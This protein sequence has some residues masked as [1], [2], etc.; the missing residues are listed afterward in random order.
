[1]V[2]DYVSG[3]QIMEIARSYGCLW[4]GIANRL[5]ERGVYNVQKFCEFKPKDE[6]DVLRR[7]ARGETVSTIARAQDR[8][9][10][11]VKRLLVMRGVYEPGRLQLR[12]KLNERQI[13]RMAQ[14]YEGGTSIYTLAKDYGCSPNGVWK[15][16][17]R[18]GV[19][20]R[21]R[22]RVEGRRAAHD[23]KYMR[24]QVEKSDPIGMAMAW[25]NGYVLEHRLVMAH[26]LGR[27]LESHETVHHI[28]NDSVDNRP[29]NLQLR[30][31]KH[32][33]GAH[34]VC[35]DCGSHNVGSIPL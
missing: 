26:K 22:G 1:M 16:L 11:P 32:G 18:R 30:N 7:Y 19:K 6:A 15:V 9:Y 17:C 27:P 5:K 3:V 23:G 34:F 8:A 2:A 14:R 20:M 21:P 13:A 28:N 12:K 4:H 31:G 35:H 10:K 33:K 24:I 29:E 25:V